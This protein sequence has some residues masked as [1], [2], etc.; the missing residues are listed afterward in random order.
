MPWVWPRTSSSHSTP[1]LI[2][3]IHIVSSILA[4][5]LHLYVTLHQGF[6]QWWLNRCFV[7]AG[8]GS[9]QCSCATDCLRLSQRKAFVKSRLLCTLYI[10]R[11]YLLPCANLDVQLFIEDYY[12]DNAASALRADMTLYTILGYLAIFRIHELGFQKFRD[13]A[14]SQEPSKVA[15]FCSYVFN[16]V[17]LLSTVCWDNITLIEL[18]YA[19]G[20]PL[21]HPSFDL[22]EG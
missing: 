9:N 3:L 6:Y 10:I 17:T 20:K 15:N 5:L 2:Q 12:T 18:N 4:I 14:M 21:E 8:S 22:D 16:E 1:G 11:F 19:T 13:I 7:F